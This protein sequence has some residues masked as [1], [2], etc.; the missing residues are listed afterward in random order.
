MP[1][2]ML[3]STLLAVGI[4]FGLFWVMQAL[5]GAEGKLDEGGKVRVVDF[6]RLKREEATEEKK[7]ELPK[8]KE[9]EEPPPPPDL[10]L[11][12]N[13]NPDS[14][15]GDSLAIAASDI[16]LG[17]APSLGTG[18]GDTD[19]VPLVRVEPIYPQR[20]Q[21]RG[22]EGWVEMEFTITPAGTVASPRVIGNH[23]SSIFDRAA[24]KAIRKWKYNPKIEDGKAVPRPGVKVRLA[25]KLDK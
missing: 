24:L 15:L 11:S 22:I 19:I 12:Q 8:K 23:P 18:S 3:S 7:R 20:A 14:D 25:F 10:N 17:G 21:Q 5:I 4:T 16:D 1:L 2:R 13:T 6:V 9:Q